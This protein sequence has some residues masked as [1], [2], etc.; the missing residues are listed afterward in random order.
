MP[1]GRVTCGPGT[2]DGG[3]SFPPEGGDA[4]DRGDLLGTAGA[5]SPEIS[6]C[7]LATASVVRDVGAAGFTV[8]E[9]V[10][11]EGDLPTS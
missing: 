5:R 3:L 4:E 6:E 11:D 8:V 9:L 7:A 2:A 1:A 10:S